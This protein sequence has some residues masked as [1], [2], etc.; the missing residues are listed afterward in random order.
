M[1]PIRVPRA[2]PPSSPVISKVMRGNKSRGTRPEARLRRALRVAGVKGCT[3]VDTEV[4]GHPDF[5]FPQTKLAV[6]VHG[7]SWH[8]CP[9]DAPPIPKANRSYWS[10]KLARNRI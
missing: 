7:C 5:I 9:R 4:I 3:S 1:R 8:R 2:P 6:F 10:A